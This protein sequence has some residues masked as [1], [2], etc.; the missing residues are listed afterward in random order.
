LCF[1]LSYKLEPRKKNLVHGH[2]CWCVV[3]QTIIY[4]FLK[5]NKNSN[6]PSIGV[7]LVS[8][9]LA[10]INNWRTYNVRKTVNPE[11]VDEQCCPGSGS[12]PMIV[13]QIN[14]KRKSIYYNYIVIA[15]TMLLSILSLFRFACLHITEIGYILD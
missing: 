9:T 12:H 6:I 8:W 13:V 1:P 7:V 4:L 14:I 15:P 2:K 5:I 3:F 11:L 10:E